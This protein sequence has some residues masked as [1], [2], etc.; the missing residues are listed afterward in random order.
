MTQLK[1]LTATKRKRTCWNAPLSSDFIF[2]ELIYLFFISVF[3]PER[4]MYYLSQVLLLL[5]LSYDVCPLVKAKE[6]LK[7]KLKADGTMPIVNCKVQC[8]AIDFQR[9]LQTGL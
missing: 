3:R 9:F 5:S 6:K 8:L 1:Y 4:E 7:L 2:C